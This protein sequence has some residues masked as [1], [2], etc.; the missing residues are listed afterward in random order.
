MT[1][2][3]ACAHSQCSSVCAELSTAAGSRELVWLFWQEQCGMKV[4]NLLVWQEFASPQPLQGDSTGIFRIHLCKD[5]LKRLCHD[6]SNLGGPTRPTC[7][8]LG[9]IFRWICLHEHFE[10]VWDHVHYFSIIFPCNFLGG[11][12]SIEKNR[13][14]VHPD[15]SPSFPAE[16]MYHLK[17]CEMHWIHSIWGHKIGAISHDHWT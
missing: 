5:F 14:R 16:K 15:V 7:S 13:P 9:D 17:W 4:C 10:N 12:P 11:I 3:Q 1:L 8:H 2:S 6:G